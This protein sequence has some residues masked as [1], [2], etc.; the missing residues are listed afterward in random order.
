MKKNNIKNVIYGLVLGAL[1]LVGCDQQKPIVNNNDTNNN[2]SETIPDSS[3]KE[4]NGN[5]SGGSS[6]NNGGNSNNDN[7]DKD[8]TGY[9]VTYQTYGD[10]F[11]NQIPKR[12][13]LSGETN[14]NNVEK[15]KTFFT[16][17]LL[18]DDLLTT[19]AFTGYV[20][21]LDADQSIVYL[22]LGSGSKDGMMTWNSTRKILKVEATVVNYYKTYTAY[23]EGQAVE[24]LTSDSMAHF[25]IDDTDNSLELTESLVPEEKTFS[26]TYGA[27]GTNT[28]SFTSVAGRVL[29]K[30]I[31]ITWAM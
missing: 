7:S 3:N 14:A 26:Q 4:E 18:Y 13:Q 11:A 2:G 10:N 6:D 31:T 29:I 20:Q 22:C 19:L 27:E 30:Y 25:K 15:M 9:K 8:V 1:L 17:G 23:V 28:F 5:N 21:S 12:T 24:G 16:T